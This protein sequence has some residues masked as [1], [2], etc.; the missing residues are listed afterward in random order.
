MVWMQE[1][2]IREIPQ[3]HWHLFTTLCMFFIFFIFY[4]GDRR[5]TSQCQN[6]Q[7]YACCGFQ[8]VLD[9]EWTGKGQEKDKKAMEGFHK[10]RI[11]FFPHI[12]H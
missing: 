9:L 7:P 5:L 12:R 3:H 1:H 6:E 2:K 10:I 11:K 8:F 4:F